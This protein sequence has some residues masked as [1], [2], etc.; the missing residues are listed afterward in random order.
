MTLAPARARL[1]R[2]AARRDPRRRRRRAHELRR[3]RAAAGGDEPGSGVRARGDLAGLIDDSSSR[4]SR[5]SG[6]DAGRRSLRSLLAHHAR[7]PQ[8]R[9]RLGRRGSPSAV[10]STGRSAPRCRSTTRSRRW[11]R[12]GARADDHRR[13]DRRQSRHRPADRGDRARRQGR[14]GAARS[15]SRPRR[16]RLGDA[17]RG[18][19]RRRLASPAIRRRSSPAA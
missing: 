17:F 19:R 3:Q 12:R 5:P 8:D 4:M 15:R 11:R 2:G 10:S 7:L 1:G 16:C 9:L 18:G 14:G 13:L 6:C